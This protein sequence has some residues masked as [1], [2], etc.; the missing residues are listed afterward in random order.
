[1]TRFTEAARTHMCFG[2]F[3]RRP[4]AVGRASARDHYLGSSPLSNVPAVV[5]LQGLRRKTADVFTWKH[6]SGKL[7]KVMI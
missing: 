2:S 6:M 7:N 4:W 1:M 5:L 3:S